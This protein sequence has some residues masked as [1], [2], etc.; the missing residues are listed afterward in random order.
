MAK[1]AIPATTG[2][3]YKTSTPMPDMLYVHSRNG[4]FP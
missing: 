1:S 4:A 2:S 3:A